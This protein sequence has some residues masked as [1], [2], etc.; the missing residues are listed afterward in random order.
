LRNV[1]A[2]ND[3]VS[4]PE[5]SLYGSAVLTL[6]VDVLVLLIVDS[7]FIGTSI[8]SFDDDDEA[9]VVVSVVTV[10]LLILLLFPSSSPPDE[11][12]RS[13]LSPV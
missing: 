5:K 8:S 10:L 4:T 6:L 7:L 1:V 2:I 11:R 9:T 12:R 3:S 13:S